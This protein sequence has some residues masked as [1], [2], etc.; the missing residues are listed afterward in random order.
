M[1]DR[2]HPSPNGVSSVV[3]KT[4]QRYKGLEDTKKGL[5]KKE[6]KERDLSWSNDMNW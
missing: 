2:Q 6:K 3:G 4:D 5:K 1:E